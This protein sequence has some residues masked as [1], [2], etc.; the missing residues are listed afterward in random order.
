MVVVF[1]LDDTLYP[2]SAYVLSALEE[3][4]RLGEQ[5]LGLVGFA[6]VLLRLFKSGKRSK[7]FQTAIEEMNRPALTGESL[8]LLLTAYRNHQP[9][10]LDWHPDALELV[11]ALHVSDYFRRLYAHPKA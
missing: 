11:K 8:D 5:R 9:V 10:R 4:G 1:D 2:E 6:S 7:L 3:V